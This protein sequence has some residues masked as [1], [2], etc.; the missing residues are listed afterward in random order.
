MGVG[1]ED[2]GEVRDALEVAQMLLGVI[3]VIAQIDVHDVRAAQVLAQVG[4]VDRRAGRAEVAFLAGSF[5]GVVLVGLVG[6][7]GV[8]GGGQSGFFRAGRGGGGG[9]GSLALVFEHLAEGSGLFIAVEE[10]IRRVI[11]EHGLQHPEHIVGRHGGA[12]PGVDGQGFAA[13]AGGKVSRVDVVDRA[14]GHDL[15][16]GLARV[17][18]NPFFLE[19]FIG[20]GRRGGRRVAVPPEAAHIMAGGILIKGQGAHGRILDL[21]AGRQGQ[22]HVR[23]GPEVQ[24]RR[25]AGVGNEGNLVLDVA[26]RHVLEGNEGVEQVFILRSVDVV[27]RDHRDRVGLTALPQLGGGIQIVV[28]LPQGQFARVGH[29]AQ[30]HGRQTES[31]D[32]LKHGKPSFV[33]DGHI[34]TKSEEAVP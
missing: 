13:F 3:G 23:G 7:R 30:Q 2:Q 9:F 10:G 17:E 19:H 18:G 4:V 5:H 14:Q 34:I 20:A 33:Y 28:D 25:A 8:H 11:A 6:L 1:V 26:A 21:A 15:A 27:E 31:N 12:G 22:F 29:G 32:L 24:V 16:A